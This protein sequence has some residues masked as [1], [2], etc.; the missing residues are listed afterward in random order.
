MEGTVERSMAVSILIM[1][2]EQQLTSLL[3]QCLTGEMPG[4]RVD[5][6]CSGE[7]GLSCLA[8]RSY[9]LI[10]ADLR[11]PGVDGLE[12]IK[13][14]RYLDSCVPIVL[15]T[16]YGSRSVREEAAR[17]GVSYYFDKPFDVNE[18][19]LVARRLLLGQEEV[20]V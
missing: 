15:M 10:I 4:S 16:G 19:L 5:A 6:A 7:E 9:D 17:L 13:G 2:D 8:E 18:M 12:L 3:Q 20:C 11:M 14:V 1:D